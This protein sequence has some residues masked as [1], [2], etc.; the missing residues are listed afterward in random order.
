MTLL[1]LAP[2]IEMGRHRKPGP[3]EPNGRIQRRGVD[4]GTTELQDLR[5]WWAGDGDPALTTYPLGVLLANSVIGEPQHT[6]G[7]H[8]AWLHWAVYGRPSVGAVSFDLRSPGRGDPP[9]RKAENVKLKQLR[10][11]FDRAIRAGEMSRRGLRVLDN[12]V[13]HEHMPRWM[14]P[15]IPRGSDVADARCVVEALGIL[16]R[17]LA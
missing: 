6:A 2:R 1:E 7:C 16:T 3:R 8:Y 13:I 4:R 5:A 17:A 10:E 12:L 11:G 14:R 15:V 9:D